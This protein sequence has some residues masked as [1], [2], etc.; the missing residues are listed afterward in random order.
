ML[1]L[2]A[3]VHI[4]QV[5]RFLASWNSKMAIGLLEV[6]STVC[7]YHVYKW[8]WDAMIGEVLQA[9]REESRNVHNRY[10]VTL[11]KEDV[12]TVGHFPMKISN[13][14][15]NFCSRR[16]NGSSYHRC[17][18]FC[19]WFTAMWPGCSLQIHLSSWVIEHLFKVSNIYSGKWTYCEQSA[20][21]VSLLVYNF[22]I[23]FQ[24]M[25]VN[26]WPCTE[27]VY[28]HDCRAGSWRKT[29]YWVVKMYLMCT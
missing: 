18:T 17:R 27:V 19:W 7:G 28:L 9:E 22:R 23:M 16:W 11:I 3:R 29:M 4:T 6:S 15:I 24:Y 20:C 2:Q 14:T 8:C 5:C 1:S 10:A 25:I 13:C 12:G 21:I 26:V